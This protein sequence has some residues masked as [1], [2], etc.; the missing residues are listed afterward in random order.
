MTYLIP[1]SLMANIGMHVCI[2]ALY[3]MDCVVEKKNGEFVMCL[4]KRKRSNTI[5]NAGRGII[6][7]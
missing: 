6:K 3:S 1:T 7:V 2:G 4:P 5:L